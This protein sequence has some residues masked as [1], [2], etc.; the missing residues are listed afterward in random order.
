MYY[1]GVLKRTLLLW[2]VIGICGLL[3]P[4]TTNASGETI[5]FPEGV[6]P[7]ELYGTIMEANTV[8]AY[9]IVGEKRINVELKVGEQVYKASLLDTKGK[10][11]KLWS[12]RKGQRV[13]VQG[14]KLPDGALVAGKVQKLSPGHKHKE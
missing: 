12:F 4:A 2:L 11:V 5:I 7:F 10:P 6:E 3:Y 9:L 14:V 13:R 1:M 8:E